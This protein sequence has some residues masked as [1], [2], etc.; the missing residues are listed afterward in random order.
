MKM[1]AH[2]AVA[3]VR[4]WRIY[5]DDVE[6]TYSS[7]IFEKTH[8]SDYADTFT[9]ILNGQHI[10]APFAHIEIEKDGIV[11]FEG[12][13]E[14]RRW[15]SDVDTIV[16]GR[17]L[18]VIVWKKWTERFEE[19]RGE[20]QGFFGVTYPE[21]VFKFIV[22]CPISDVPS[23]DEDWREY[24]HQKIGWG[25]NPDPWTCMANSSS[26][27]T[28][29]VYTKLRLL[30]FY[31]RNRGTDSNLVGL[32][33]DGVL[34]ANQWTEV[35]AA[36][37]EDCVDS[38]DIDGEYI[39]EATIGHTSWEYTFDDLAGTATGIN[40]V[41]CRLKLR[42]NADWWG[43]SVTLLV[44]IYDGTT[45]YTAGYI[46]FNNSNWRYVNLN[47]GHILDTVTKVN[48]A[49]VRLT[50]SAG[51]PSEMF[52]SCIVLLVDFSA[53]GSQ[54]IGDYFEIDI[55]GERSRICAII[56]QSRHSVDQYPRDYCIQAYEEGFGDVDFNDWDE[57]DP[58]TH[59]VIASATHIDHDQYKNEDAHVSENYGAGEITN[60]EHTFRFRCPNALVID[61]DDAGP[62]YIPY[63]VADALNDALAIETGN[64]G[65]IFGGWYRTSAPTG[66]AF[67]L[68][69]CNSGATAASF[70]A[71]GTFVTNTWYWVRIIKNGRTVTAWVYTT[72][73]DFLADTN[74]HVDLTVIVPTADITMQYLYAGVTYNTGTAYNCDGDIEIFNL[75]DWED[76][77]CETNNTCA[78][79]IIHSW[80][81]RAIERLRIIIM[82]ANA[83]HAWEISQIYIYECDAY[84]Y[85]VVEE[86]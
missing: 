36:G 76:L 14:K 30:D 37:H 67:F 4:R 51:S 42:K 28:D 15:T 84:K 73:A 59:I 57:A 54:N 63:M 53:G 70:S 13:V 61:P 40:S 1:C 85:C 56:V 41:K 44:E 80:Q 25:I 5:I 43:F 18:K 9:V 23:E 33:P 19:A 48:A 20:M 68:E 7:I 86:S 27:G 46:E 65:I 31:W 50:K 71:N 60:F 45:W 64:D 8:P 38:C 16:S 62:I 34:G 79:D 39:G 55:G 32:L 49:R 2:L 69:A 81:P 35:P 75:G 17:C 24:P 66:P 11:R 58:N 83:T 72:E 22:R 12:Y 52:C 29:P 47:V 21:E 77:V 6:Y 74:R 10:I 3:V 78:Q 82:G 26:S